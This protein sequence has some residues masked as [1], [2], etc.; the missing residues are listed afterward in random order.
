MLLKMVVE[1]FTAVPQLAMDPAS[2]SA[3]PWQAHTDI[4]RP[5]KK[6][7]RHGKRQAHKKNTGPRDLGIRFEN[8]QLIKPIEPI[9]QKN[10]HQIH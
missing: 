9:K 5:C 7:S 4:H 1:Q 6:L 2:L 3:M 8:Y 10:L